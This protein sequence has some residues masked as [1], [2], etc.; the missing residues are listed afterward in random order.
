MRLRVC[1]FRKFCFLLQVKCKRPS[2]TAQPANC[3][4]SFYPR[5]KHPALRRLPAVTQILAQITSKRK[6]RGE[7]RPG[8]PQQ[9]LQPPAQI[10]PRALVAFWLLPFIAAAAAPAPTDGPV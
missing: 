6:G 3:F 7:A 8:R 10:L 2:V 5:P 9:L 1:L 4:L